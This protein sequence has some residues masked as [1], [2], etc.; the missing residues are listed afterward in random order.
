M[1]VTIDRETRSR[2]QV[3]ERAARLASALAALGVG[4]GD[5]VALLAYNDFAMIEANLA[6]RRL[7]AYCVPI[8][9]HWHAEEIAYVLDDCRPKV[10]IGHADLIDR[11]AGAI[12]THCQVI[13]ID[14][15]GCVAAEDYEPLIAGFAPSTA[16]GA[17]LGSSII[18][19][20]GTT[21]RPKGVQRLPASAAESAHRSKVVE[22][23]YCCAAD[24]VALV[25]GP[26][27]HLF[28]QAF[29]MTNF[30]L[31]ASLVIMRKFD[32]AEMLELVER[33]S[34]THVALVPTLF[35]RLLRLPAEVR[36]RHDL[37]SLRGV[38]HTGA[39][40]A[41]EIKRAMIAWLGPVLV[42]GYGSSETGVVTMITSPEW[43][44][45]EGSVGRPALNG[46]V[47][48]YD[49]HGALLPA[50]EVGDIYLRIPGTPDF[51]FR[52]DPA[53]RTSVERDGF[54]SCGDIGWLDEDGYLFLCDRRADMLISGGV[55]VYP[56]EIEAV[57]L[58]HP[59][60]A[61]A[62][63]FGVPDPEFGEAVA[64]WIETDPARGLTAE[65]VIAH[66]RAHLAGYKAPRV[67]AFTAA[68]PREEN[69]K[70]L[71]RKL[72]ERYLAERAEAAHG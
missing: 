5:M 11:A 4:A 45:R 62:A 16:S 14:G 18:Y 44:A 22:T 37:S 31:G 26:L 34:I 67:V 2:E 55:N 42:E 65:A 48:I 25:T 57:L 59:D 66:V 36:A 56:A 71:K 20:S 19:T 49:E 24:I 47:R 72:R 68:M 52:G 8:N 35:G 6:V 53:K 27:Y 39:P 3:L 17:G 13:A 33:H 51:T 21:G 70:I 29:A 38:I 30:G 61:D 50:G 1:S 15:P 12:P 43:L 64:A 10:L 40:C 28:S 9:W 69:G 32:A 58:A 23:I 7:D 54:I 46:E 63:V 60:I 41:P